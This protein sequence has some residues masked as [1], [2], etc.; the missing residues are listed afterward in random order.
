MN[1]LPFSFSLLGWK[2][3]RGIFIAIISY[4][5]LMTTCIIL[6]YPAKDAQAI[7]ESTGMRCQNHIYV[8]IYVFF[9]NELKPLL[10]L[11][12][13]WIKYLCSDVAGWVTTEYPR[14]KWTN[15]WINNLFQIGVSSVRALIRDTEAQDWNAAAS[16]TKS[17]SEFLSIILHKMVQHVKSPK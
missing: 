5:Y 6:K 3:G 7:I 2:I 13:S 14:K 4:H 10:W 1:N 11:K 16:V 12:Y 17:S 15:F 8:N 9:I